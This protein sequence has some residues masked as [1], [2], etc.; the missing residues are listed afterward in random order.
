MWRRYSPC[1]SCIP[2]LF[3]NRVA[4]VLIQTHHDSHAIASSTSFVL[5]QYHS[6]LSRCVSTKTRHSLVSSSSSL[7]SLAL[8]PQSILT[9]IG[10]VL[11]GTLQTFPRLTIL[12]QSMHHGQVTIRIHGLLDG[13]SRT[14]NPGRAVR[15]HESDD[16]VFFF[17]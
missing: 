3:S 15:L 7:Y 6:V 17:N 1:L 8:L 5:P 9:S 10:I 11:I 2:P 14:R 13:A 4:S 12:T 16:S